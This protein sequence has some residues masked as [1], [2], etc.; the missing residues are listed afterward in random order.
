MS[1]HVNN[2]IFDTD[3]GLDEV[4]IEEHNIFSR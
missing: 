1:S 2:D 4:K 3:F